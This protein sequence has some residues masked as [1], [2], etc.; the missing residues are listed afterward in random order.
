[1][2][3][4]LL[5]SFVSCAEPTETESVAESSQQQESDTV[6]YS[7]YQNGEGEYVAKTSGRRYDGQTITFLT[8]NEQQIYESEIVENVK[9]Y[10]DGAECT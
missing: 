6:S 8:C 10:E 3:F 2:L 4:C 1:M 7:E 5:A 9:T